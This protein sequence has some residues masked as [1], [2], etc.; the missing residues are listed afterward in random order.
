M[1]NDAVLKKITEK[2][3]EEFNPE[4]IIMFGSYA[5]GMP[6]KHSDLDLLVIVSESDEKPVSRKKRAHQCL[7]DIKNISMDIIVKTHN[8]AYY[9]KDVIGALTNKILNK[10]KVL[11]ASKTG[12]N[13][14][15]ASKSFS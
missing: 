10:G 14:K 13:E 7:I 9:Y 1:I 6:D 4:Q 8:E 2:L 3:K 15:L 11:Y 5:Y 12:I